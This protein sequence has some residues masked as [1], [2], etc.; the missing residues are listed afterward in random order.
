MIHSTTPRGRRFH[1]QTMTAYKT[2]AAVTA[3][4]MACTQAAVSM[5]RSQR[6]RPTTA[7][8][9]ARNEWQLQ[10]HQNGDSSE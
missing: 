2:A 10:R 3:A 4:A 5:D 9:R 1:A 6:C 7:L 8:T